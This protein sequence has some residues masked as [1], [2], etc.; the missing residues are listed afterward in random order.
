MKRTR[1][2]A[3]LL[4]LALIPLLPLS[5][6][7]QQ[8]KVTLRVMSFSTNPN[9]MGPMDNR[10]AKL[11]EDEL[12]IVIDMTVTNEQDAQ[13]Q[14][15]AMIASNDLPDVFFIP[16]T[17][18]MKYIDMM[19]RGKQILALDD[20]LA[21]YAPT[22]M[23]DP[24][25]Q[26][27]LALKRQTLSPD[28]KV[29]AIGMNRGTFDSG[30]Q[31][32]VGQFI[33]WDLYK[34]LGYPEMKTYDEDLLN[35]LKQMQD[36][37]NKTKDGQSVYAVGAWFGDSQ[38][39]GDWHLTYNMAYAEGYN[40][41]T[42]GDRILYS[43]IATNKIVETNA[44]KDKNS[45]FWRQVKWYNKANQMGILDPDSF[46]QKA[47]QYEDKVRNGRYLFV[48]P[49][50]MIENANKGYAERG[51]AEKAL[52]CL[53]PIGTDKFTLYR[54]FIAGQF[55]YGVSANCK[56]PEKAVQLLDWV[57]SYENARIL[58]NGIE[59]TYWNMVDGVPTPTEEYLGIKRDDPEIQ[60]TEGVNIFDKLIGYGYATI[61]PTTNTA[62]DLYSCSTPA[63]A[64]RLT[65]VHQDM[66]DHYGYKTLP[67]MYEALSQGGNKDMTLFNLGNLPQ[68]LQMADANLQSYEFKNIFKCIL[69]K[70]D[71]EFEK[72]QDEYIAGLDAFNIDAIY[73][74]WVSVGK[75]QE[76]QLLPIFDMLNN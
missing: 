65:P 23:A 8:E 40:C 76:E 4:V 67:E 50:W 53:P 34:Q 47:D 43:D 36:L 17:D 71:A 63:L 21:E 66:L 62:L 7:A 52:T 74:Y 59:G 18:T 3:L 69:A 72:L 39:W 27:S 19:H 2:L 41:L 51:E 6:V 30:I 46:T 56:Y 1:F 64:R 48:N 28:G 70:D 9:G 26:A 58:Y 73:D 25:A 22:I 68:D 16:E 33:R 37:E 31:P 57:S 45:I 5:A 15:P 24:A 60:K 29:Y 11:I 32:I 75:A 42:A 49:G 10:V 14:L 54:Y 35:V 55:N 20:Y 44:Q 61:D 13:Q 12:G 38:G